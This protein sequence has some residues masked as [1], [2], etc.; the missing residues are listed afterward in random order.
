MHR[1]DFESFKKQ[2]KKQS[3]LRDDKVLNMKDFFIIDGQNAVLDGKLYDLEDSFHYNLSRKL[4]I[5][6][7]YYNRIKKEEPKLF[8]KTVNTLNNFDKAQLFR[9]HKEKKKFK[10]KNVLRGQSQGNLRALLSDRY[11]IIDNQ[12]VINHLEPLF[13]KNKF[14]LLSAYE[15]N[16]IM[17]LKIRF[18]HL[19]GTVRQG[20]TVFGGIYL[21]NSEVGRSSLTISALIYRLVCTN[22]LMLPNTESI[23]NT[24]HLGAKNHIGSNPNYIIPQVAIDKID[25]IIEQL[26]NKDIFKNHIDT[27]R[28]TANKE[29]KKVN[30]E[31]IKEMYQTTE[32]EEEMIKEELGREND[33]TVY[34]L[35]QAFTSTARKINNIQ[36]SLYLEKVGGY[37]IQ[38]SNK[39]VA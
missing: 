36:R 26:F 30:Y 23:A 28:E 7:H 25:S 6:F 3:S 33:F 29:F 27:L 14:V 15:D 38:D 11:K 22:G 4:E 2:L 35:I 12:E 39:V 24:F 18:P 5:P 31:K 20:D 13:E 37:L 9:T 32:Q 8:E 34:G 21:R 17:S 16:N 19:I 10:V 1:Y